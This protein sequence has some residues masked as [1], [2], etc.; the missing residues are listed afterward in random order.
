MRRLSRLAGNLSLACTFLL[1]VS[2]Y[3][4]TAC[5][6]G[7]S[8]VPAPVLDEP[9]NLLAKGY[10]SGHLGLS[11][12][13]APELL[14]LPDPY[15]PTANAR[16]KIHDAALFKDRYYL[17]FGPTPALL[18]FAPFRLATSLDFPQSLAT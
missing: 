16:W 13:P 14:A 5:T 17:Y 4:W 11:P 2:F 15:E 6:S 18:V 8:V 12:W 1:I 9:Y 10:L 3:F 7:A